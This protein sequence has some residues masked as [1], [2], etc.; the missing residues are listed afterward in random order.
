MNNLT[1][2]I[3]LFDKDKRIPVEYKE[4]RNPLKGG[5]S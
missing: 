2:M 5:T 4:L 1:Q 3:D